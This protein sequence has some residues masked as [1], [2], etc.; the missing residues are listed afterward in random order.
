MTEPYLERC[1]TQVWA[2]H[3]LKIKQLTNKNYRTF[4]K[5]KL[6]SPRSIDLW[7]YLDA[8]RSRIVKY[9]ILI[10]A[11]LKYTPIE[12]TDQSCL[13]KANQILKELLKRI[14]EAM[15]NSECKLARSKL[16][17]KSE[18]DSLKCI[19]NAQQLITEGHL[20]DVQKM[21]SP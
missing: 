1:K 9:P 5:R 2:R 18:Y 16:D 3:V 21:V 14:D 17:I 8:P 6:A 19:E 20:T 15:G 7:T 10:D 4:V 11:I 12:H 13:E